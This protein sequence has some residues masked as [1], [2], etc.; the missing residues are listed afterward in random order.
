M[1]YV[2]K[3]RSVQ[4][5]CVKNFLVDGVRD[6][7]EMGPPVPDITHSCSIARLFYR[8]S[9][10]GKQVKVKVLAE[11]SLSEKMLSEIVSTIGRIE[12]IARNRAFGEA[13]HVCIHHCT[14]ILAY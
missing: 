12:A 6:D 11:I 1:L 13:A 5:L 2:V 10:S 7:E 8:T 9:H 3:T 14:S 4:Q